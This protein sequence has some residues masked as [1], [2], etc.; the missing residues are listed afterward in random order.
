MQAAATKDLACL[1]LVAAQAYA[2]R[3][4]SADDRLTDVRRCTRMSDFFTFRIMIAPAVIETL[5]IAGCLVALAGG[6]FAI[7]RGAT[8]HRAG[9]VIIGVAILLF[10]PFVV[11]LYCEVLI[12]VFRINETLT[13]LRKLAIS[14]AE[15]EYRGS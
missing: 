4:G 7:G 14:A 10:T 2:A 15:R 13:D 11:R 6:A 8:D 3:R 12:V 9:E 5:F 1:N